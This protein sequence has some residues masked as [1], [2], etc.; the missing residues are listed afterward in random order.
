MLALALCLPV[1]AQH[2]TVGGIALARGYGEVER[3]LKAKGFTVKTK[4]DEG[5]LMLGKFW[6]YAPVA[7][8]PMHSG[9][10]C[11]MLMMIIPE[12][13]S[14]KD[15]FSLYNKV[16]AR[17]TEEY[18]VYGREENLYI[19]ENVTDFSP[20]ETKI[21]A[22]RYGQAI[23]FTQ[24]KTQ[25]GEIDVSINQHEATGLGVF[26]IFRDKDYVDTEQQVIT[27]EE[28]KALEPTRLKGVGINRPASDV[29]ADLKAKGLRDEMTLMER[30]FYGKNHITKLRGEFF[31]KV[32]CE[33]TVQGA[34][35]VELVDVRFPAMTEWSELYGLYTS[36]REALAKKYGSIYMNEDQVAGASTNLERLTT[37]KALQA[38]R[39]GN[40]HL[41]TMMLNRYDNHAFKVTVAYS[42]HDDTYRVYLIYYTPRGLASHLGSSGDL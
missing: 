10:S 20:V 9:D 28:N 38:I 23:L 15:L 6:G 14:A 29:V 17:V 19:D 35:E 26:V 5:V 27:V 22:A 24:F 21:S 3:D 13:G 2:L 30:W 4:A 37:P 32:G 33:V 34:S 16:R 40:A 36:L 7:C 12:P 31:G 42:A 18:G 11:H 1:L 39:S 41:V 8:V 25:E